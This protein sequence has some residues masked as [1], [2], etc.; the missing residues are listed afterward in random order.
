MK[1]APWPERLRIARLLVEGANRL[2]TTP[3]V[4]SLLDQTEAAAWELSGPMAAIVE[5][6]DDGVNG[7]LGPE[8]K[9]FLLASIIGLDECEHLS[10]PR[11]AFAFPSARRIVCGFCIRQVDVHDATPDLCDFCDELT[12]EFV[13][14]MAQLA[15]LAVFGDVCPRCAEACGWR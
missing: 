12:V 13:P 10:S 8:Q 2:E 7:A 4:R 1:R 5:E 9:L 14:F 6:W 11:P 3:A 15:A